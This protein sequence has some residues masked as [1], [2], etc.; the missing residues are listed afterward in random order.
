MEEE[1]PEERNGAFMVGE[2]GRGVMS[3]EGKTAG[4]ASE[5][6][7]ERGPISCLSLIEQT[8]FSKPR[9]V[10]CFSLPREVAMMVGGF[11]FDG[12]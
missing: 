6:L 11:R 1:E 2:V 5:M 8:I 10:M 7:G 4:M 3:V 9:D 12:V